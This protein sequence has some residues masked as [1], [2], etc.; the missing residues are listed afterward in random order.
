MNEAI[1]ISDLH[2][3]PNTPEITQRFIDFSK[4]VIGKTKRLYILGDFFHAWPGDDIQENWVQEIRNILQQISSADIKVYFLVGNRDFLVGKHFCTLAG[5]QLI[6][7]PYLLDFVKDRTLLVHGDR[8]CI[9][10]RAHQWFRVLTRNTLFTS[11]FCRLPLF[12]RKSIV[13]NVRQHSQNNKLAKIQVGDADEKAALSH[14]EHTKC[15]II[16][17]GHT[18]K[19]ALHKM[20]SAQ[21]VSLR[22]VL[23]DW[24]DAPV[25]LCYHNTK[26]YK[27]IHFDI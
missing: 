17:H 23:S 3:G 9:K 2:L 14:L 7:E 15:T 22:Y 10:D 13:Q 18:H 1:F 25:V 27:F 19:P 8:Y 11:L 5:M 21:K 24:D 6:K 20:I 12:L 16:I 4:W 26:G